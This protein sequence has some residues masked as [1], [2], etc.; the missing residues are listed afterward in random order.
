MTTQKKINYSID[1]EGRVLVNDDHFIT[2][3]ELK[4]NF[5]FLTEF[6]HENE[7]SMMEGVEMKVELYKCDEGIIE[8]A[9]E[10]SFLHGENINFTDYHEAEDVI[11]LYD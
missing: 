7:G 2:Y 1:D 3:K 11:E 6:T 5:E 10:S 9:D 4:E 8:F